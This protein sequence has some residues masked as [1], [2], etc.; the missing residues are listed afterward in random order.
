MAG[1]PFCLF[2]LALFNNIFVSLCG[3]VTGG[4]VDAIAA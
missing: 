2:G 4:M 1:I 3:R